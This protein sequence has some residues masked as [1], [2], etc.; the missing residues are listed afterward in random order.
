M[1]KPIGAVVCVLVIAV[2][3][4]ASADETAA[5]DRAS[6][7]V[8][9]EQGLQYL[10]S[11]QKDGSIGDSRPKAVTAL[12]LL[13]S[14]SSGIQ[15]DDPLHGPAM[16]NAVDWLLANS[17]QAFLGGG[18]EPNEDHALAAIACLEVAGADRRPERAIAVYKKARA[19]LE[20]SLQ[21][22]DKAA[23][24]ANG[25]GWRPDDKTRTNDRL[26]TTWFL[27]ECSG[28]QLR[29]EAVPKGGLDRAVA[30]VEASQ[31]TAAARGGAAAAQEGGFSVDAVG[32]PVRSATAAGAWVLA[33]YGGE[34]EAD[35]FEQAREWLAG[36][37]P[38]WQGPHFY[39]THFF[40]TR[41]LYRPGSGPDEGVFAAYF[42]RLVRMLRE[43]QEADGSFPFPPGHGQSTLLMGRG[44]STALAILVLNV[45]RG[46]LPLDGP[47]R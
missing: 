7:R 1:R 11:I 31:K 4:A 24:P 36:H 33:R 44:Y 27:L 16:E 34:R 30:F 37:P 15:L 10:R 26:L 23:D 9:V 47:V 32:L 6:R 39:A 13:A 46:H 28:A 35:R 22:Q 18:E 17:P 20:F 25:G 8:M 40:A 21:L 29:D 5:R 2:G 14:L 43:R 45:D 41:A 38:R 3:A 42:A 19:A 12:F